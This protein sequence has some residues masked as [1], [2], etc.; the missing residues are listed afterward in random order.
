M[1]FWVYIHLKVDWSA[2]SFFAFE[3]HKTENRAWSD[4][5]NHCTSISKSISPVVT[6]DA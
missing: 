1:I 3:L 2:I 4:E 5:F 6:L